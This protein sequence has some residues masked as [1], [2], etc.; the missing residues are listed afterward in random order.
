[1][2]YQSFYDHP[3]KYMHKFPF[4]CDK[5]CRLGLV[6]LSRFS[7]YNCLHTLDSLAHVQAV[8]WESRVNVVT[9]TDA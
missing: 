7:Y 4:M 8:H 2:F 1:M 5:F 6:L 9:A 3:N